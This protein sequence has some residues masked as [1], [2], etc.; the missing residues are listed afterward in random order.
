MSAWTTEV[1]GS[2]V[3]STGRAPLF[4]MLVALLVTFLLTRVVTRRI[5]AG[6]RGLKNWH[7]AG[8]HVHHQVFGVVAML[9]AGCLEFAY[10]PTAPW[11]NLLGAVFGAGVSLT[12]DEFAL[13]LHL[14]DVYWT[15]QGRKSIDAV[16]VAVVVTALLL[17]GITPLDI[18]D[19]PHQVLASLAAGVVINLPAS[20]INFL[21]GKPIVGVI[22]LLLPLV[23]LVGATRLAKPAS[24][25]AAWRYPPGSAK[26]VRAERRFGPAYQARWNR[27][28]DFIGGTP[29]VPA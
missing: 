7:V 17:V 11:N 3:E 5:R 10:Q 22:G 19:Q 23:A 2:A 28:R 20:V 16:F 26:R 18:S 13:W 24:Q 9:V 29:D 8:V 6:A 12:L 15:P 1:Y 21:K 27:L 4:W 25:W 14:D